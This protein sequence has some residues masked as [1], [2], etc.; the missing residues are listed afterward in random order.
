MQTFM[1]K[2]ETDDKYI[3]ALRTEL[4]KYKEEVERLR[5]APAETVTRVVYKQA[6]ELGDHQHN[7]LLNFSNNDVDELSKV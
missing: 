2:S 1:E 5:N 7:S 6:E 4:S 3:R